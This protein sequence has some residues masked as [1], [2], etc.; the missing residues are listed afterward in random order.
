MNA[1]EIVGQLETYTA[2]QVFNPHC[3]CDGKAILY[4]SKDLV[5]PSGGSS[6]PCQYIHVGDVSGTCLHEQATFDVPVHNCV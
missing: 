4:S 1:K 2:P 3:I 6:D 5:F